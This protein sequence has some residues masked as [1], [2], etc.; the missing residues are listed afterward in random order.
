MQIT[1]SDMPHFARGAAFLGT[2]GGG[3]PH[4]GQV[5]CETAISRYGAPRVISL[6]ELDPD[7]NVYTIAMMG[8]PTVIVEKLF[9]GDDAVL[10]IRKLEHI[11]GRPATALMPVEIGGINSTLPIAIAARM[12]L[13]VVD[14][15]GM[16]RAFPEI[17]MTTFNVYGVPLSP[18]VLAD[19]HLESVVIEARDG[20]AAELIARAVAMQMGLAVMISCYPMKG[21]DAKR[22]AI[23]GTMGL[24]VGI[25]RAIADGR[26]AGDPV[27]SLLG[28]LRTTQYYRHCR[29]I[30]D[31]KIIDLMRETARGFSVGR[32]TLQAL[33]GSGSRME[34]AFQNENLVARQDGRLRAMVPDLICI[35][36]RE[37]AEPITT[38]TLKYG[39]RAKVIAASVPPTMRTPPAIAC[40]GPRAFGFDEDF[41]PIEALD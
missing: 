17:Q 23:G 14:A 37:T 6:D 31:G 8:A 18:F 7:A 1:L 26:R 33:D 28:Y 38:E 5:F 35:V 39:L 2:G 32:C 36:D 4:L 11:T 12:G 30:F 27:Q 40:F 19:E 9:C 41:V 24:A 16:G 13:P 20:N 25:G 15:D 10:A 21:A 22:A 29:E 34:I 3:D